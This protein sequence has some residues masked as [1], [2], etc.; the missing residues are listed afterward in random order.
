[1]SNISSRLTAARFHS[2][3]NLRTVV[4]LIIGL[5]LVRLMSLGWAEELRTAEAVRVLKTEPAPKTMQ[6]RLRGVVTFFDEQLY[7]R[8][9]QDDTAGIYLQ[10]STNTPTLF[11]GQLVEIEGATSPGEYA[12]VVLVDHVHVLGEAPLPPSKQVNYEQLATGIEDSQFVEITGVVRSVRPL[13]Q[14]PYYDIEIVTGGGRL[15]VYAKHLPVAKAE[16]LL[17]ST[18]RVRGVCSTQFNHQRQLFAIRLMVPR[19]D[20]LKIEA[21]AAENPYATDARPIGSLLQFTP[22]KSYGHRVKLAGTV[23]YYDPGAALFL[24]DSNHGVEIQTKEHISLALGDRVEALGFVGQ[25]DYTPLLQDAVYRKV[26]PGPILAALP[27]TADGALKGEHDCQL[28]Q[29][30]GRLIDRTQHANEQ[31]LILQESNFIFQASLK[32]TD[33]RDDFTRLANGSRVAVTGVCRI[34]PGKWEAGENWRAKSF[35]LLL[36]SPDDVVLLAAPSWWTLEKM[37]WIASAF[38][39]ATLAA[40]SWI[41]VLRRQV[42]ERTRELEVQIQ[43]RQ[44]AERRREIEQ[45]RARVAH[46]LHDDLGSRLTEVNMLATLAK[47]KTTSPDEK[48]RYLTELTA[49]AGQMVTSLDEI[50]WAVNPR[51]DT[52]AS[53]ASYFGAYAER[54]LDMA[55]ITCGLDIA[56]E[57]PDHPL[58]PKFRQELFF[59]FKEALNN[60]LR[61]AAATQVWLRISVHANSLIVEVADNGHGFDPQIRQAGDDGIANM[62]ERMRGLG[63]LCAVASDPKLGTT[64]RFQAPLPDANL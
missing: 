2:R 13:E 3:L 21:P 57:L 60:V 29:V 48:E 63:G 4:M 51:N 36:R 44:L 41:A 64:V 32:Q 43:Q 53:L 34:E 25:G 1:M 49:T 19:P 12:P 61:H 46:D 33:G 31:F 23:I 18:V 54:L 55:A 59:A 9:I 52:I 27:L 15:L 62:Y 58:N 47:S 22:Q 24:Q 42:A 6:V 26:S 56:E 20:D 5:S 35:S 7:S 14:T 45:E 28:I 16:D 50:V 37:L 10:A 30:T 11:P 40:F 38:A 17:D 8:F 39:C